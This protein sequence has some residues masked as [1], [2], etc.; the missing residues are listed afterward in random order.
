MGQVR[1]N[2]LI[3]DDAFPFQVQSNQY[4]QQ[5]DRAKHLYYGGV[6]ITDAEII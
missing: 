1:S 6:C 5:R 3:L 2:A 4:G